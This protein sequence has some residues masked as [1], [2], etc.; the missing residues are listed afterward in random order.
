L[1]LQL[2][3]LDMT[4]KPLVSVIIIFLNA[5]EFLQEA[6]QSVLAQTY[7]HWE[8]FLVDDGS[9]DRST[10]IA[11]QYADQYRDKVIYL[12]HPD[13]ENRGKGVSRN[14][15][16]RW[17]QGEYIAFLDA[18]D[19]WL[20]NKLEEQVAILAIYPEAGMLYGDTLYWYSWTGTPEDFA[21][22][23]I[24][25]LGVKPNTPF[26]P[27]TLLPLYLRGKAAV[28][29]TCSVLVKRKVIERVGGFD[30]SSPE[31]SNFYE[32]QALYAKIC[33]T[34]PVLAA[35]TCWDKYRQRSSARKEDIAAIMRKDQDARLFFLYWLDEYMTQ[36][37]I[38]DIETRQALRKEL[39]LIQKINWLPPS[40]KF[41]SRIRWI[42]K[43]LLRLA[44][45]ILPSRM[46]NWLWMRK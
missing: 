38:E 4:N 36:C 9:T 43:W 41:Q 27:P 39:W 22:D 10:Q 32:D 23:F 46:Q 13:H 25:K 18:D 20:P 12:E 40:R 17:A 45:L 1:D 34:S 7:E 24:P 35:N 42:K 37:G 6:I 2:G 15:G 29:C 33:L 19:I 14:L 30:E 44:D 3:N 28:P 26:F 21:K 16:M 31:I 8:L 5:E 11:S